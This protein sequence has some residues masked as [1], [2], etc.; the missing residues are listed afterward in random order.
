[1]DVPCT[2][3]HNTHTHT[4]QRAH[5]TK[6]DKYSLHTLT[7]CAHKLKLGGRAVDSGWRAEMEGN[8]RSMTKRMLCSL[9]AARCAC[10]K[11]NNWSHGFTKLKWAHM[12]VQSHSFGI[13]C[14]CNKCISQRGGWW[15]NVWWENNAVWQLNKLIWHKHFT[16]TFTQAQL[17]NQCTIGPNTWWWGGHHGWWGSN[18]SI[19]IGW[20]WS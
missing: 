7:P 4:H 5:Q 20:R 14:Y 9:L 15:H 16:A 1:M 12:V 13:I 19:I 17:S 8:G 18:V 6:D 11:R 3:P 10:C 2:H